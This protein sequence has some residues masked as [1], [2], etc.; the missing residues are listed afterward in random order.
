M[1]ATLASQD[2]PIETTPSGATGLPGLD[3]ATLTARDVAESLPRHAS[4]P[5]ELA[6]LPE[7]VALPVIDQAV[8]LATNRQA[9][10]EEAERRDALAAAM[11][12]I[13]ADSP[14]EEIINL[15]KAL[16]RLSVRFGVTADDLTTAY[17]AVTTSARIQKEFDYKLGA[18]ATAVG[19]PE[20]TPLWK[21]MLEEQLNK[22]VAELIPTINDDFVQRLLEKLSDRYYWHMAGI[23]KPIRKLI[24]P[25]QFD[26]NP[27]F[28]KRIV[29]RFGRKKAPELNWHK[30]L[31]SPALDRLAECCNLHGLNLVVK[32]SEPV[33]GFI[34]TPSSDVYK[35]D[36]AEIVH[37]PGISPERC[38][39]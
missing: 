13:K 3:A 34:M 19:L 7:S 38:Y 8:Q 31:E 21:V 27:S 11:R 30:R 15:E 4:I 23:D 29:E 33:V 1:N 2:R 6:N 39:G 26:P 28:W 18:R 12:R 14:G 17:R 22:A 32:L 37:P 24:E 35:L 5:R 16:P 10:E 20:Q 36:P 25:Y 9:R